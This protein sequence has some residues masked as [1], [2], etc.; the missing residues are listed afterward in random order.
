MEQANDPAVGIGETGNL[1]VTFRIMNWVST[2]IRTAQIILFCGFPAD[3]QLTIETAHWVYGSSPPPEAGIVRPF[4]RSRACLPHLCLPGA[5]HTGDAWA[6]IDR[7][8][9]GVAGAGASQLL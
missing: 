8:W 3:C 9:R 1:R 7:T 6:D 2:R 5:W 4:S